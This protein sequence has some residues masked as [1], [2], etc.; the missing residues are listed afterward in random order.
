MSR[1]ASVAIVLGFAFALM[2]PLLLSPLTKER[3]LC[4]D[5]PL[6]RLARALFHPDCSGPA[7]MAPS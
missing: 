2:A 5:A 6:G 4:I 3:P 1:V 7:P